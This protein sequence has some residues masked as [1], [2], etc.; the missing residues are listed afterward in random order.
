[1]D[2]KDW[3]KTYTE[4]NAKAEMWGA[5]VAGILFLFPIILVLAIWNPSFLYII[6]LL[7]FWI[8]HKR[9]NRRK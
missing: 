7:I 5:G 1:M 4:M 6:P 8:S 9:R 2:K 3:D